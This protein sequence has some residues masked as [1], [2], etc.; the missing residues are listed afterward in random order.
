MHMCVLFVFGIIADF[1]I[2]NFTTGFVIVV[3]IVSWFNLLQYG[4]RDVFCVREVLCLLNLILS[5]AMHRISRAKRN[6]NYK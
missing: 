2:I 4:F 5:W 3:E 6:C 1:F